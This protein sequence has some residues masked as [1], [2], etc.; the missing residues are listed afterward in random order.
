VGA[1]ALAA[2]VLAVGGF[3]ALDGQ[4]PAQTAQRLLAE[5]SAEAT[6]PAAEL[7]SA[8]PSRRTESAAAASAPNRLPPTRLR[9]DLDGK[10]LEALPNDVGSVQ[11]SNCSTSSRQVWRGS[12][13]G[14]LRTGRWC[15][16]AFPGPNGG[17][18]VFL[19]ACTGSS[20]QQ[21]TFTDGR[22]IVNSQADKCLDILERDVA[23]PAMLQLSTCSGA[24]NQKWT[25][26]G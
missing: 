6:Q 10:C 23:N 5:R 19:A 15:L 20:R 12:D 1:W 26:A 2:G 13:D 4:I 21:W 22:G 11:M 18:M 3:L 24:A 8:E 17:H 16:E 25:L 14:A 7:P 9:S